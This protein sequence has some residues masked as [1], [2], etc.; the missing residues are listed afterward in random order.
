MDEL[1]HR[2]SRV[3]ISHCVDG[4]QAHLATV[5][6]ALTEAQVASKTAD[7][8]LQAA[9]SRLLDLRHPEWRQELCAM[10]KNHG[11]G[12]AAERCHPPKNVGRIAAKRNAER[13]A[14]IAHEI[15]AK[16]YSEAEEQLTRVELELAA[17]KRMARYVEEALAMKDELMAK[18]E[19]E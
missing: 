1:C 5:R 15:L 14:E 7:Q 3:E 19:E 16:K 12:C 13:M 2:L 17:T 9:A 10:D 18:A 6:A 4:A 11:E 8:A